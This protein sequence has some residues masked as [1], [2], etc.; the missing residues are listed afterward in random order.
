MSRVIKIKKGLDIK[1]KGKAEKVI[2][3][4]DMPELVSIRLS[5]F[6]GITPKLLVKTDDKVKAGTPLFYDKFVPEVVFT[7]PVSGTVIAINRGERRKLLDV[8]IKPDQEQQ[9]EAFTSGV[10]SSMSRQEIKENLTKSGVWPLIRQRP[11]H[12]IA[13]PADTPKAI[14]VT[15]FDSAPLAPDYNFMVEGQEQTFQQGIDA[16]TKLTDGRVYLNITAQGASEVFKNTKGVEINEFSGLHPA[17]NVGVQINHIQPINKGDLVWTL[18]APDVLTIGRLFEKGVFD[19]SRII[20]FT[21]SEVLKPK[22]F[23]T[24]IGSSV[25]KMALNNVVEGPKRC[26]SGNVL[27]GTRIDGDACLGFYDYQVTVIPEDTE[28]EMLGWGTPGLDK[29][30]VSRSFFSWLNPEKEWRLNSK[31]NG[32][33]RPFVVTGQY[34]RVVPMDILP[35][36]LIKAIIIEDIDLMEQL[37]IYEIAEEDLALCEFVCTSKTEVQKI[38]RKGLTMVR[39]EFS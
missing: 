24:F 18:Q 17:G 31:L 33:H 12:V 34:D 4:V 8:V 15:A 2:A 1:L 19:A 32:G 20:A 37:G 36:Q 14:F 7:S 27:T 30:S 23:R 9:F 3:Q 26:I 35:Q 38:V 21:G 11:F 25:K 16:L 10:P 13:N 6:E 39:K 28:P 5:D 29:Y 22:Y